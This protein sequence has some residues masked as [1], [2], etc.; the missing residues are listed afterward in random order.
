MTW[1]KRCMLNSTLRCSRR[2]LKAGPSEPSPKWPTFFKEEN[3][4][5]SWV[6]VSISLLLIVIC[7]AN[8]FDNETE[9]R[10]AYLQFLIVQLNRFP[11]VETRWR[12][13]LKE[14]VKMPA[15]ETGLER[16]VYDIPKDLVSYIFTGRLFQKYFSSAGSLSSSQRRSESSP[17]QSRV[18]PVF[19]FEGSHR[20]WLLYSRLCGP[21][22]FG[23]NR[24]E[25]EVCQGQIQRSRVS[26]RT[27]R[28]QNP[29]DWKENPFR[30][31]CKLQCYVSFY[32]ILFLVPFRCSID[33]ECLPGCTVM[34]CIV[35][36]N[37]VVVL[38]IWNKNIFISW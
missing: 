9:D 31:F 12:S 23:W 27:D 8:C 7:L 25:D 11:T 19:W 29:Q 21:F 4:C 24:R 33:L 26:R 5:T 28:S 16:F 36:C 20:S 22:H 6:K 13:D 1:P 2:S 3:T 32:T 10:L 15:I 18:C 17:R 37:Y 14:C 35:Y 30:S 34:Y 38:F